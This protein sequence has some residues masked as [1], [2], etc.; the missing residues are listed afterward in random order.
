VGTPLLMSQ[1][2]VYRSQG[3]YLV[4]SL[5]FFFSFRNAWDNANWP[6]IRLRL[7]RWVIWIWCLIWFN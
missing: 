2:Y 4:G 6:E 7:M 3:G 5:F 1:K